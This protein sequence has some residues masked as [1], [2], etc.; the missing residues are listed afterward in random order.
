MKNERSQ[1]G[2]RHTAPMVDRG[3]PRRGGCVI[4]QEREMKRKPKES[5]EKLWLSLGEK[6]ADHLVFITAK[7]RGALPWT[8]NFHLCQQCKKEAPQQNASRPPD[9]GH[10]DTKRRS[11]APSPTHLSCRIHVGCGRD[12]VVQLAFLVNK[13]ACR[14]P[15]L[16]AYTGLIRRAAA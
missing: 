12:R 3:R 2:I 14:A 15:V 11:R 16:K 1:E 7:A 8:D 5:R 9:Q 6:L 4:E 13:K 10:A